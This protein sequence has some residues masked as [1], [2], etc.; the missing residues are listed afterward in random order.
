VVAEDAGRF[1]H[2]DQIIGVTAEVQM[3]GLAARGSAAGVVPAQGLFFVEIQGP[4]HPVGL[5][6]RRMAV[7]GALGIQRTQRARGQ[8]TQPRQLG[9]SDQ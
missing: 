9:A 2:G 7:V 4:P 1:G 6:G 5:H 8:S 3:A